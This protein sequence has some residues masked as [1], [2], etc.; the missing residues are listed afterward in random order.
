MRKMHLLSFAVVLALLCTMSVAYAGI[1][2]EE[3]DR[4]PNTGYSEEPGVSFSWCWMY[5]L[6]IP[7]TQTYTNHDFDHDKGIE[8][9]G[10]MYMYD[11]HEDDDAYHPLCWTI[12]WY[13]D[14]SSVD[15]DVD[16][17]AQVNW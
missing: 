16:T 11:P 9:I 3:S 14:N 13:R 1:P 12:M 6:Y 8:H 10:G 15:W 2:M 17:H 5:A 4:D 7:Q